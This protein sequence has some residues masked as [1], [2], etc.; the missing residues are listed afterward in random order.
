MLPFKSIIKLDRK[1][2]APLYIQLS[3]EIIKLITAGVITVETKLPGSRKMGELL[4]I[5]R[6]TII[7]AYEELE[8]QGWI[9][10][11]PNQGAYVHAD[12]PIAKKYPLEQSLQRKDN[13]LQES[14]FN[15]SHEF[16]YL[17]HYTP[18]DFSKIKYIF[19]TGYPDVRI[20]PMK[21]LSNSFYRVLTRRHARQIMNYA[22]DFRGH[23][24]LREELVQYLSQTRGIKVS[25]DNIIITRGSLMAFTAIFQ[26]LLDHGDKVVVGDVSFKVANNIIK[27]AGGEILTVPVDEYGL[28]LDAL[29]ILCSKQKI[30]AV[31][32]M[33]HHH[34]PTTVTLS[35]DRRM[36]LLLLAQKYRF[37]I[38]EDDYDYD[39][40]YSHSPILPMA[41]TDHEGVVIYVGSFS[42]TIAPGLRMGFIVAPTDFINELARLSRFMDVHGNT[43]LEKAIGYL[44]QEGIIRRHL[45]KSLKE[46]R[47]RRDLFCE[48]LQN[49]L[50][51]HISFKI[52][53][54]GLATWVHFK[55]NIPL[56]LLR[57][58]AIQNGLLISRT[59]FQDLNGKDLNAIRMGFA[60]LNEEE[61]VKAI[62]LLRKSINDL[63]EQ[64]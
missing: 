60:S 62:G 6:R 56:P 3:N 34:H 23:I 45:K 51:D 49:K 52:P 31:F 48:L 11:K 16:D 41:S 40:H 37:A 8:A 4:G 5:S 12:I 19:D 57:E 55:E 27:I 28:D 25:L 9:D 2:N 13:P 22:S 14:L 47:N 64:R 1:S 7:L 36:R 35:A 26:I 43:A 29:E 44:F 24:L 15:Y 10:I 58:K 39:F 46:Y 18:P 50:G 53:E 21:E 59:V 38:I 61:L 33:P 54:G 20:G 17:E 32:V 30:R 42:K 63:E